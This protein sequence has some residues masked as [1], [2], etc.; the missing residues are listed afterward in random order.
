MAPSLLS[1]L[2]TCAFAALFAFSPRAVA[3]APASVAGATIS[4]TILVVARDQ[5]SAQNGAFMGLQGYGIPYEVLTVPQEGV[6]N[7][8][9]LNSSATHG[10]YGGI[11][12]VSEVGYNYGDQYYSALTR[13]QWNQMWDYQTQFGV[14]MVRL[15][16][17]PTADF[18]TVSAVAG[19]VKDE[20]VVITNTTGFTT[21]GLKTYVIARTLTLNEFFNMLHDPGDL[22]CS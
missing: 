18:G 13:R 8:P 6:A 20:P 10:N 11:V 22:P 9:V 2:R 19:N 3:D 21:A 12:I 4:G 5:L 16:V 7:L 14:R 15:D 1:S 17:F